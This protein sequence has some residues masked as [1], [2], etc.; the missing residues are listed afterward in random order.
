[1]LSKL[2]QAVV[3]HPHTVPT[4][5]HDVGSQNKE[6]LCSIFPHKNSIKALKEI[7]GI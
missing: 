2:Q 1:M 4:W 6:T 3:W 7:T 5:Y